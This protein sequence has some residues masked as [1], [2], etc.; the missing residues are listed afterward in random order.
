MNG[1][2]NPGERRNIR[3][4]TA[5]LCQLMIAISSSGSVNLS[6][7]ATSGTTEKIIFY[8]IH[9]DLTSW[10]EFVISVIYFLVTQLLQDK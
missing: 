9:T 4:I 8:T 2:K 3:I 7:P 6:N 10:F 5:S 1:C